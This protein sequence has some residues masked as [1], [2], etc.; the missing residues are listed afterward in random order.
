MAIAGKKYRRP[1]RIRASL[2]QRTLFS[3]YFEFARI[4]MTLRIQWGEI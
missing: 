3:S 4:S 1:D 2:G